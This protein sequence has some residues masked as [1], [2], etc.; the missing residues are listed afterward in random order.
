MSVAETVQRRLTQLGVEL[1]R[2]REELR[3]ADEELAHFRSEAD[4]AR[5]QALVSDRRDADRA[6]REAQRSMEAIARQRDRLAAEVARLEQ[7]QDA[8]LD[9]LA[10]ARRQES[11]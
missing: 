3:I 6:Q 8:L 5:L 4:D 11:S 1:R 7:D 10:D 2:V 9:R